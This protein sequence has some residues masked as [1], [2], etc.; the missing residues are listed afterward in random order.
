MALKVFMP[1]QAEMRSLTDHH[2]VKEMKHIAGTLNR[3]IQPHDPYILS[4]YQGYYDIHMKHMDESMEKAYH[5]NSRSQS[6]LITKFLDK[7]G[8]SVS[9]TDD[10][11]TID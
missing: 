3:Y 1:S 6:D 7:R 2:K 11:K 9:S 4:R 10:L 5:K 8:L